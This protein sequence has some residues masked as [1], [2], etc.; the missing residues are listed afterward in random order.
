MNELLPSARRSAVWPLAGI[1][2]TLAAIAYFTPAGLTGT[3]LVVLTT[4]VAV[5]Y[6]AYIVNNVGAAQPTTDQSPA[7]TPSQQQLTQHVAGLSAE[8]SNML[9]RQRQSIEKLKSDVAHAVVRLN[10]SFTQLNHGA[11]EQQEVLITILQRI[12]GQK[13]DGARA[14]TIE[15]FANDT[16]G[17]LE[18]FTDLLVE[19]SDKSINSAHKTTDMTNQ[20]QAI[21][22][23]I[24]QVKGIAEQTN[25]LALNAAIEAARAGEAGRGFAVVAQEVRKLSKDSD[26]LNSEI[27]A[28]AEHAGETIK[29]VQCII[30]EMASIDM[31]MAISAKG[32]VDEMLLELKDMNNAMSAA[33]TSSQ[34]IGKEIHT[35]VVSAIEALQFED[36]VSQRAD[37]LTTVANQFDQTLTALKKLTDAG[38]LPLTLS[39]TINQLH[40]LN[41][42]AQQHE[43]R[44][45]GRPTGTT[46]NDA[47]ELF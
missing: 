7:A 21:F 16:R 20:L 1:G 40:E 17:I 2:G 28:K 9:R 22:A 5:V 13:H 38:H 30:G 4:V 15:S 36:F 33:V 10:D 47:I 37:H 8:V 41:A 25:L 19:V 23:L 29:E 32:H 18:R 46:D 35:Q 14:L 11:T 43:P 45:A 24:G 12:S 31:N 39:E 26:S 27:R 6:C 44:I 42:Q 34:N 3:L